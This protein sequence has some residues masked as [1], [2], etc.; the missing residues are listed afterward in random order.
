[1][2][3]YDFK[4]KIAVRAEHYANELLSYVVETNRKQMK[5]MCETYVGQRPRPP[6]PRP[7]STVEPTEARRLS[8][9]H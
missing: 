9:L 1:M 3:C 2:N 7:L 6:P 8:P 5:L 4:E